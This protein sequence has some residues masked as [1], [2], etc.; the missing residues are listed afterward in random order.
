MAF[1]SRIFSAILMCVA[2]MAVLA[3][4]TCVVAFP[5][6]ECEICD[7][8]EVEAIGE[9]SESRIRLRKSHISSR[10]GC[11]VCLRRGVVLVDSSAFLRSEHSARNG[12]GGPLTS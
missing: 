11:D 12:F 1:L 5:V 10:P 7:L 3:V 4:S 9:E 6:G 2:G 8:E